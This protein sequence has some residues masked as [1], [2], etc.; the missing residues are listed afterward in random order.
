[1]TV[2]GK[3]VIIR[4]TRY[5]N[6]RSLLVNDMKYNYSVAS[7]TYL[8]ITN[9]PQAR[10]EF[11]NNTHVFPQFTYRYNNVED[12]ENKV[13]ELAGDS[14]ARES[15][16]L[17]I[18]SLKFRQDPSSYNL[19]V[20]RKANLRKYGQPSGVYAANFLHHD[21]TNVTPKTENYLRYIERYLPDGFQNS[22]YFIPSVEIFILLKSYLDRYVDMPFLNATDASASMVLHN[23][24]ERSGLNLK[25]WAVRTR[26]GHYHAV[27]AH[28]NKEIVIGENYVGR[29]SVSN[30][31]IALHEVYGHALR[32]PQASLAESEGFATMLEQL[33]LDKYSTKRSYRFLAVLLGWGAIGDALDFRQTYE[34]IWRLMVIRKRYNISQAK[35]HAFDECARAFRGGLPHVAGSVYLK[36][37]AYFS[38]NI[39]MWQTFEKNPPTYEEFV[40]IIEGRKRVLS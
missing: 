19:E 30:I 27:T 9:L 22:K 37:M 28:D 18:A 14:P 11:L 24:L 40:D 31:Q 36:D 17:V 12:I 7:H 34:V 20:Y 15:L 26:K 8:T 1:M 2:R 23:Y 16:R 39:R 29:S 4:L 5:N 25:G 21:L 32:G 6:S 33:V 35:K 10:E 3:N 38:A 13:R